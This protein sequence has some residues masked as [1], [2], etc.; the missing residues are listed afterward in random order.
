MKYLIYLEVLIGLIIIL[1]LDFILNI[2]FS[3]FRKIVNTFLLLSNAADCYSS[4]NLHIV[5]YKK[6]HQVRDKELVEYYKELK[7]EGKK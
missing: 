6:A 3:I 4:R 2:L 5:Q 1:I 7:K